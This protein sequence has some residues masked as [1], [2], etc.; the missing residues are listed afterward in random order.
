MQNR[1]T[2]HQVSNNLNPVLDSVVK[3]QYIDAEDASKILQTYAAN[4]AGILRYSEGNLQG[5][6][7]L[8]KIETNDRY[9]GSTDIMILRLIVKSQ[10][11]WILDTPEPMS[12]DTP[13]NKVS[14]SVALTP[15]A[16]SWGKKLQEPESR[17]SLA[18]KWNGEWSWITLSSNDMSLLA[19]MVRAEAVGEP[20]EWQKAVA[21]VILNR[22]LDGNFGNGLKGVLFQPKQ[23]SPVM[24]GR[25]SKTPVD[26]SFISMIYDFVRSWQNPLDNALF[27]QVASIKNGWINKTQEPITTIGNHTFFRPKQWSQLASGKWERK[28]A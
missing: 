16:W 11:E 27:F 21:A 22:V 7:K 20:V 9:F 4:K 14:P 19:R 26:K 23:F 17:S 24:D 25:F 18:L 5:L 3:K 1:P 12:P 15:S 10:M 13:S 8:L 6:R 28:V 2:E